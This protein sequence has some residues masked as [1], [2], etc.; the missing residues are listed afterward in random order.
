[1]ALAPN[2]LTPTPDEPS[3]MALD[4]DDFK[5]LMRVFNDT[6]TRLEST[7]ITL[8]RE[9]SRL[10]NELTKANEQL[11]RSRALAALGEM[12][13]GIAHEI[14]NPLGS[15][16]LYTQVL[17]E[18]V[19]DR[20]DSAEVCRKIDSAVGLLD[21]IVQDVLRFAGEMRI[22]PAC[23]PVEALLGDTLARCEALVASGDIEVE[24]QVPADLDI[25]VDITLMQMAIG[26]LVRNAIEAMR[27]APCSR[28]VLSLSAALEPMR[29]SDGKVV[30]AIAITVADTGPG[31]PDEVVERMFNP[32]FTTRSTGT[33]LGLAIVHRI[34]DAHSGQVRVAHREGGGARITLQLPSALAPAVEAR[35]DPSP[36]ELVSETQPGPAPR[37]PQTGKAP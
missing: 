25:D 4:R 19:A 16:Q 8:R 11:R 5:D 20:P 37:R 14:R 26:N 34:V 35:S 33:G 22:H 36:S 21:S 9:V 18:D 13:A 15:I 7:H 2:I 1:M 30:D 23:I 31:I 3:A 27:E 29:R 6:T 24:R 28:R 17:A 12:A 10:Q 32:F